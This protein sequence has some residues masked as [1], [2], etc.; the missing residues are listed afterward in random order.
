MA[1]ETQI[2][3]DADYRNMCKFPSRE[4]NTYQSCLGNIKE[5]LRDRYDLEQGA[6]TYGCFDPFPRTYIEN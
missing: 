3:V 2:A 5:T 1:W 4:D 6:C